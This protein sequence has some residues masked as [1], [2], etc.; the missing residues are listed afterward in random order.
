M[1]NSFSV[2]I[3]IRRQNLTSFDVSQLPGIALIIAVKKS[4]LA[5]VNKSLVNFICRCLLFNILNE[6]SLT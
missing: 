2:G 6:F 1:F 4:H 5:L 3:N